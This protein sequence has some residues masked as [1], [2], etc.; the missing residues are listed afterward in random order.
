MGI[1]SRRD[2]QAALDSLGPRLAGRQLE[3]L[4]AKLNAEPVAGLATEWEVVILAALGR[5]GRVEHEKDLGGTR[6]LDIFFRR[7]DPEPLEFAA[8]IRTVSDADA[9]KSNRY[10]EFCAA[11]ARHLSK[12]GHSPAGLHIWVDDRQEGEF[13]DQKVQ[14]M[15]PPKGQEDVFVKTKLGAFLSQIARERTK[16]A[17][18]S[19]DRDG[20]RLLVHFN[21]KEK[22]YSSGQYAS[23]TAPYSNHRNPLANA[24]KV[25]ADQLKDSGYAGAKGIIICDGGCECLDERRGFSG[26]RCGQIVEEFLR[27]RSSVLWVLVIRVNS[28]LLPPKPLRISLEPKLYWNKQ[29]ETSLFR[30]TSELLKHVVAQVPQP[31][32]APINALQSQGRDGQGSNWGRALGGCSMDDGTIRLSAR[33]LTELLAG[34]ITLRVFL[35]RVGLRPWGPENPEF[36]FFAHQLENSRTLKNVSVERAE[37]DDD[38]WIVLEYDGPDPAV[39]PYRG[40]KA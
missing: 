26:S 25:K 29:G 24:L 35:E 23:Y 3:E 20:I 5:L 10:A 39:S 34:R 15:L 6:R 40:R 11:V 28:L 14:L 13:E 18:F 38:D 30:D 8:D 31:Q 33:T 2:I 7:D 37:H 12:L 36:Q 21:S 22:R 27:K 32:A 1:F 9:H 4:V 16:D 17:H 19:Y